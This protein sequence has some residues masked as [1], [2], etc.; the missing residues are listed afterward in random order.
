MTPDIKLAGAFAI[1]GYD[2]FQVV[3]RKGL[4]VYVGAFTSSRRLRSFVLTQTG[5]EKFQLL[6]H[7]PIQQLINLT[8]AREARNLAR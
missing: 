7:L 4:A 6:R 8:R 2:N 1:R 5:L 3:R